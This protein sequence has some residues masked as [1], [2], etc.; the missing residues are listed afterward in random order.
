VGLRQ[1]V[2]GRFSLFHRAACALWDIRRGIRGEAAVNELVFVVFASGL[3]DIL[4]VHLFEFELNRSIRRNG[5]EQITI[6]IREVL[7]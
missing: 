2:A 7:R 4:F 3:R 6:D 5:R 1:T